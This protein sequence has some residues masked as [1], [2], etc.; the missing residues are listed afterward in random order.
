M[1]RETHELP[2]QSGLKEKFFSLGPF[3][4]SLDESIWIAAGVTISYQ[5]T[6]YIPPIGFLTFPWG[7]VHYFIPTLLAAF[8]ARAKHPATGKTLVQYAIRWIQIRV[9]QRV[10]YYR[11]VNTVKGG[12]RHI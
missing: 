4:F 8:F 11:K 1:Y 5:M 3:S 6:E 10:F 2:Y 12:D 7:Y 9:R